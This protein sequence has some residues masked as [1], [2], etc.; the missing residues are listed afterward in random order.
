MPNQKRKPTQRNRS[1]KA[2]GGR[3]QTKRILDGPPTQLTGRTAPVDSDHQRLPE[4]GD[5]LAKD[6]GRRIVRAREGLGFSQHAVHVRSKRHDP[7]GK[8]IS[9]SVLSMYE[10]GVNRPG[11]REIVILCETL[12]VTPNWLLFGSESPA[13]A[14]QAS[15]EF[16]AGDDLSVS[17]RLAYAML[18]LEPEERDSLAGLLFALVGRKLGDIKLSALMSLAND[19]RDELLRKALGDTGNVRPTAPLR[20]LI[21]TYVEQATEGS[22]SNYGNLRRFPT[23]DENPDF[24]PFRD[25]PPPPRNLK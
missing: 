11:A 24:D 13:K 23:D 17:I 6:I 19:V 10:T 3:Q 25:G 5:T 9:R 20:D 2:G 22:I 12:K 16:M 7:E 8:G 18:L 4:G 1:E 14:I 15:M 21:A